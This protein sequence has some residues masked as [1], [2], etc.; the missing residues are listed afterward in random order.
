M[1]ALDIGSLAVVVEMF[2][3]V[4]ISRNLT[5]NVWIAFQVIFF[6]F[7]ILTVVGILYTA[8]S[9]AIP[10]VDPRHNATYDP[11]AP[12]EQQ[13]GLH[14][15][16]TY[17]GPKSNDQ[18]PPVYETPTAYKYQVPQQ[19][20]SAPSSEIHPPPEMVGRPDYEAP[21][22]LPSHAYRA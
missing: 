19:H 5:T 12:E 6:F 22:E 8:V 11:D 2:G 21:Y 7:S 9:A 18:P 17:T 3:W 14:R 10:R 20:W 15:R 4:I 13:P 1:A 16:F